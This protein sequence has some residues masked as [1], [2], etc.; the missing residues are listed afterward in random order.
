VCEA[1]AHLALELA[2]GVQAR[3]LVLVLDREQLE[4]VAGDRVRERLS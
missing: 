3:D 1:L 2:V 4:I